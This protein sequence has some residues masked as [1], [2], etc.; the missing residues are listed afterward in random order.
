MS[1]SVHTSTG[2][3][4]NRKITIHIEGEKVICKGI[5]IDSKPT[6][7]LASCYKFLHVFASLNYRLTSRCKSA[8][9]SSC[10]ATY[11]GLLRSTSESPLIASTQKD[12]SMVLT[13]G[14]WQC[15]CRSKIEKWSRRTNTCLSGK[16]TRVNLYRRM[17][18]TSAS[19]HKHVSNIR[20][21]DL[22]GP[23]RKCRPHIST[24]VEETM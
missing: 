20:E 17:I 19:W 4:E 3:G 1:D 23:S 7:V 22:R 10:Q 5:F 21:N 13:V 12:P 9:Q 2:W 11:C 16:E 14:W 15:A 8:W 24:F 18:P 6:R